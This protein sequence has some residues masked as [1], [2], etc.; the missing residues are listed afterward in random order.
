MM[1]LRDSD[2][3]GVDLWVAGYQFP[4]ADDPQKRFSWHNVAGQASTAEGDWDFAFAALGCDE[5]PRVSAWL[6]EVHRGDLPA[7]LRFMEPNLEFAV[8]ETQG[9][10]VELRLSL[11][12]EFLPPWSSHTYAGDPFVLSIAVARGDISTAADAW[13]EA[14]SSFPDGT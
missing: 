5:T 12:L 14:A 2:G 6:R 10:E 7:P 8:A 3:H 1:K 9:D 4:D 11:D 13:D